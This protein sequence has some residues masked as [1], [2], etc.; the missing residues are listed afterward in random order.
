MTKDTFLILANPQQ[1]P[2]MQHWQITAAHHIYRIGSGFR[3]YRAGGTPPLGGL[4]VISDQGYDSSASNFR[5]SLCQDV[6]RECSIRGFFGAVLDFDCRLPPLERF[7]AQL[8]HLFA[9][10]NL[11]VYV[12][13]SYGYSA[14]QAK[15][16]ISSALSGGSLSTRLKEVQERFG[17]DRIV[18]ALER[19]R[20]DF[21][22]PSPTGSGTPLSGSDLDALLQRFHPSIFFS[23]EL[24]A[25]YFTY[26]T[27]EGGAHFVLF[28]DVDTLLQKIETARQANIHTFL[29]PWE[30]IA[31]CPERFGLNRTRPASCCMRR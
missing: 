9:R 30:E 10:R 3:L 25:R 13:E 2:Q 20:E 29:L 1:L 22:L 27:Q 18:L 15:V 21:S 17:R 11:T 12:P 16:F 23:R 26:L 7:A 8:S 31:S 24:C 5:D 4:M 6:L 28:D 14:P 19:V